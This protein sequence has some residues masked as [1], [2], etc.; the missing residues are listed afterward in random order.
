MRLS[1]D[2]KLREVIKKDIINSLQEKRTNE[3]SYCKPTTAIIII[4]NEKRRIS[5]KWR[6]SCN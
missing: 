2:V 1:S 3:R 6:I 5:I 4:E